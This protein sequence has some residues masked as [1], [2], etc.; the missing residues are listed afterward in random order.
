MLYAYGVQLGCKLLARGHFSLAL[1]FFMYPVNY[2]RHAEY[3]AALGALRPRTGER[4][5]DVGSPK[6]FSLFLAKRF[7][8]AIDATDLHDYFF[9]EY[10]LL[11]EMERLPEHRYRMSREDGRRLS[12][13]DATFDHVYAISVVEHIPG[14]GDAACLREM[15][16][17]L[18]PGGCCVV[19]VPFAPE[20]HD[21][22]RR[23]NFYWATPPTQP[24]AQTAAPIFYQRRYD[25]AALRRRLIEP[26]ALRLRALAYIGERVLTA[27]RDKQLSDYLPPWSGPLHPLLSW[28]CLTR[29]RADWK[30]LKKPLCAVIVLEKP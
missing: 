10:R 28:L 5:L 9:A 29:P 8:V 11:R 7:G 6:L 21:E 12:F 17:V 13:A 30:S 16:R 1:R 25:E 22:L 4:I 3:A 24:P 18:R 26:S 20:A 15:A 2:W 14:E 19:T 27:S 23:P